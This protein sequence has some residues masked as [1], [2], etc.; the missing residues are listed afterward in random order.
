MGKKSG[1]DYVDASWGPWRGCKKLSP[2]CKNCYAEREMNRVGMDFYH[3]T[4]ASQATFEAPLHWKDPK[5]IMVCPWSDFFYRTPPA[6]RHDALEIIA[7]AA[8]HDFVVVTKRPKYIIDCFYGTKY[9]WF[10][11]RRVGGYLRGGEFLANVWLLVT[12][13]N[14]EQADRRIPELLKLREYGNW[15]VLGVSVE[16]MLESIDLT[17]WLAEL[18]WVIVGGESGKNARPCHPDWVR[19]VR[20]DCQVAAVAFWFKQWGEWAPRQITGMQCTNSRDWG[21]IHRNGQFFRQ[22]TPWNGHDDD[23][24]GEAVVIKCTPKRAGHL[25]DG[26][27]WREL[28]DK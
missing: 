8:H 5:R 6:W 9:S 14:Q 1:I 10:I 24:T 23:G 15:P 16:P 7:T 20:D 17:P 28:P 26:R 3:I 22:T 27:E 11:P 12:V 13:E 19:K 25:L 21:T 4:R 18:D 2:G